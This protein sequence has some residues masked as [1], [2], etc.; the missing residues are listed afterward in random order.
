MEIDDFNK[1]L[2]TSFVSPR[3]QGSTEDDFQSHAH[4]LSA[5]ETLILVQD[6]ITFRAL[7]TNIGHDINRRL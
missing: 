2:F 7:N 4:L 6:F 1:E 3:F 5:Q